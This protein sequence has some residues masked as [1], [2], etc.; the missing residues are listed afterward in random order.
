MSFIEGPPSG[1]ALT[2]CFAC[3]V[4]PGGAF[5]FHCGGPQGAILA[6]P[7]GS[8]LK[9]LRNV[10]SMRRFAT[11]H[12]ASWYNYINGPRGRGL[13]NGE[14][15]L[16]TGY[17]KA[18][19]WGMASYYATPEEFGLA[20]KLTARADN[21][22]YR[23]SGTPGQRN[24]S[25]KKAYDRPPARDDPLNHTI[26][27]H[28]LSIS[29]G[30]DIWS[31]LVGTVPVETS[32]I[33]DFQSRLNAA[34]GSGMG[35]SYA[36]LFSLTWLWGSGGIRGNPPTKQNGEVILSDVSPSARVTK[37]PVLLTLHSPVFRPVILQN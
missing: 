4:F 20:F 34:G 5:A 10:D 2:S 35:S 37:F 12:A 26:F 17:E 13:A 16:V 3:S 24:P 14:L 1:R 29:L 22:E 8:H 18:C 15:Y 27:I 21:K 23:W 33:V 36:S 11:Q 32:S 28:G 30:T 9:K 31:R 6:L 25:R 19:S 7:H